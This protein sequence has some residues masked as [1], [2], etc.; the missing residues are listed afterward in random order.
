M[1]EGAGLAVV[2][3]AAAGIGRE[4]AVALAKNGCDV[5][6]ACFRDDDRA[7]DVI[8]LITTEGRQGFSARCDVGVRADVMRFYDEVV[9]AFRRVPDLLVNNA[10][11]ASSSRARQSAKSSR[12]AL[13]EGR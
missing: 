5:A 6:I 11:R 13:R 7:P 8:R 10:T 2:T 9:G 3:G 4:T 1:S 12:C